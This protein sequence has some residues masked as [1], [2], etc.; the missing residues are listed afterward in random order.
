MQLALAKYKKARD[1]KKH[2]EKEYKRHK[3]AIN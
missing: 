2:I 1:N 3:I